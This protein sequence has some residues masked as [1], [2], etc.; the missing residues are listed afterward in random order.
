MPQLFGSLYLSA[1][2][3]I[4]VS[5]VVCSGGLEPGF[6]VLFSTLFHPIAQVNCL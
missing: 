2:G 1:G 5:G 6:R 3:S 4:L